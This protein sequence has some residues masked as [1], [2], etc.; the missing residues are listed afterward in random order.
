MV[1][2]ACQGRA[3]S[4]NPP[5]PADAPR[6][7]GCGAGKN[8]RMNLR[9]PVALSTYLFSLV[10]LGCSAGPEASGDPDFGD[11]PPFTGQPAAGAGGVSN[12]A[13]VGASGSGTG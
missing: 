4:G 5:T 2:P 11:P 1:L 13:P 9:R 3:K 6:G 7:A 8:R 12:L 10:A